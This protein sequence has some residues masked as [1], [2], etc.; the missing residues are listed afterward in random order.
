MSRKSNQS[1]SMV[2]EGK[3]LEQHSTVG[4]MLWLPVLWIVG[5]VI[6]A[7]YYVTVSPLVGLPLMALAVINVY[8]FWARSIFYRWYFIA[9][10][11]V[12]MVLMGV[13]SGPDV[14]SNG[15]AISI[16]IVCYLLFSKRARGTFTQ[17]LSRNPK[18]ILFKNLK[19]KL[20]GLLFLSLV[21]VVADYYI[22][23]DPVNIS[24]QEY[25][26]LNE[27]ISNR[28]GDISS[29]TPK[30]KVIISKSSVGPGYRGYMYVVRGERGYLIVQLKRVDGSDQVEMTVLNGG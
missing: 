29:I 27:Q 10:A 11:A 1:E 6:T 16:F 30:K 18:S 28:I 15:V 17:P 8:L 3:I 25:I 13:A 24:F 20:V 19:L 7:G 2:S 22:R 14:A 4:G 26:R 21:W 23:K 12:G 5:S 9:H